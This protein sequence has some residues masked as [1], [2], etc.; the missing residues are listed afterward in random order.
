[1]SR[2]SD[3]FCALHFFEKKACQKPRLPA[4]LAS[5]EKRPAFLAFLTISLL[6]ISGGALRAQ[7]L[8]PATLTLAIHDQKTADDIVQIITSKPVKEPADTRV[9]A[10]PK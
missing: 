3:P 2:R 1:M 10:L 8:A 7:G 9:Q 6:V 5:V 4:Y